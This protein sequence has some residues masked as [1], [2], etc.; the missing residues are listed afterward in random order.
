MCDE[1]S[2]CPDVFR[3]R[4]G[5][6]NKGWGFLYQVSYKTE[7]DSIAPQVHNNHNSHF[8]FP[9]FTGRDPSGSPIRKASMALLHTTA[10]HISI[11]SGLGHI[12]GPRMHPYAS[13]NN[14]K[15][16]PRA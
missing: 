13:T 3:R 1:Q 16:S 5:C 7:N 8:I 2:L 11:I 14:T 15:F 4:L 6:D 10:L 9:Q 12:V